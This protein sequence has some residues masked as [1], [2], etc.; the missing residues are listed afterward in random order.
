MLS[1]AGTSLNEVD[2]VAVTRGPGS[3]TGLRI[4][5]NSMKGLG[6][7]INKPMVAI[8]SLEALAAQVDPTPLTIFP[9]IDAFRKEIFMAGYRYEHNK[10]TQVVEEQVGDPGMVLSL[11]SD[12]AVFVGNGAVTYGP[13]LAEKLGDR[14][15]FANSLQHTIRAS[16]VARLAM[17]RLTSEGCDAEMITPVYVRK[18]DAEI[19]KKGCF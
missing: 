3:F 19:N 6:R 2:G 1:L 13:V 7:A 18:C 16:T 4:G 8:S 11:V 15:H 14:A 9:L 17:T 10:L 5:L 12:S